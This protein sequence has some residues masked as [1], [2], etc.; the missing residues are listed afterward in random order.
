[1]PLVLLVGVM[2]AHINHHWSARLTD[3]VV[4]VL[5]NDSGRML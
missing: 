3:P 5:L 2:A 1:M 4:N